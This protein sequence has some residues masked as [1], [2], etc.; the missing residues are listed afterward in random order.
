VPTLSAEVVKGV[1]IVCS[2][3]NSKYINFFINNILI[4]LFLYWYMKTV[5]KKTIKKG[6]MVAIFLKKVYNFAFLCRNTGRSR[7]CHQLQGNKK[8]PTATSRADSN[9]MVKLLIAGVILYAG[10]PDRKWSVPQPI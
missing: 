1:S 8:M 5:K 4:F 3:D 10:L 6:N 9:K 7:S 2:I